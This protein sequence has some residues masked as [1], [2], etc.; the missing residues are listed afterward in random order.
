MSTWSSSFYFT[1][2]GSSGKYSF[3][4]KS[5]SPWGLSLFLFFDDRCTRVWW[6]LRLPLW[7]KASVHPSML[8]WNGHWLVCVKA[9]STRYCY[10]AKLLLHLEQTN[11]FLTLWIFMC[12]L[13]L[14]F[15]LKFFSHPYMSHWNFFIYSAISL[16]IFKFLLG[17][18]NNRCLLSILITNK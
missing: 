5:C 2:G 3:F 1:R 16:Y 4:G 14:Y 11:S 7:R 17:I 9:C 8:H 13:R 12:R 10:N 15:V 18:L 6:M